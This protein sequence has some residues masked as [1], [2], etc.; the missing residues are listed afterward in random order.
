MKN[1][2]GITLIALIITI[3]VLLILVAVTIAFTL[4]GG[5]FNRSKD[6]AKDTEMHMIYEI[7][8]SASEYENGYIKVKATAEGAKA[9]L[10]DDD[11]PTTISP[12]ALTDDT[13]EAILTVE[14]KTGTFKYRITREKIEIYDGEETPWYVLKPE[15]IEEIK[16]YPTDNPMYFEYAL[17]DD[18]AEAMGLPT[19]S[20]MGYYYILNYSYS[21]MAGEDSIGYSLAVMCLGDSVLINCNNSD[22]Q[23]AV[24]DFAAQQAGQGVTTVPQGVWFTVD[25]NENEN[26]DVNVYNGPYP[27]ELNSAYINLDEDPLIFC[28]TYLN[29][30]KE[31]FANSWYGITD[32][33]AQDSLTNDG[34]YGYEVYF[35]SDENEE[36]IVLFNLV[37]GALII[38]GAEYNNEPACYILFYN[39]N[40]FS[41]HDSFTQEGLETGKWYVG[42]TTSM[43]PYDTGESCIR[44]NHV[45]L[46]EYTGPSPIQAS[47]F[48]YIYSSSYLNKVIN[49]FS[50]E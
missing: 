28:P 14:G 17:T 38:E 31:H 29:R 4:E 20:V 35:A 34:R 15:E 11:K 6:A 48:D 9:L 13:D 18:E 5:L 39:T 42:S 12:A 22:L 19:G 27:Y 7:I 32:Q 40:Y 50:A 37:D 16:N 3:I 30:V 21:Y 26:V 2:K 44:N 47:D 23:F 1:N 49:S 24:G 46:T 25:E 36:K 43:G 33:E 45:L 10:E 41:G 8:T